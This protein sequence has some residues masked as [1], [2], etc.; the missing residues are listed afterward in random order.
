M[1]LLQQW[2]AF[3]AL[4]MSTTTVMY[5]S[6]RSN[7]GVKY[8]TKKVRPRGAAKPPGV[9]KNLGVRKPSRKLSAP[10]PPPAAAPAPVSAAL[11]GHG[12]ASA[13]HAAVV[14]GHQAH[15]KR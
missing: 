4:V 14:V 8:L 11:H 3:A 7:V 6:I 12:S 5:I 2:R 10:A 15:L 9:T 13:H 1:S